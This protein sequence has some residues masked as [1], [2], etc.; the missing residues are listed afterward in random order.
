M[1]TMNAQV[2][3]MGWRGRA[4]LSALVMS[5]A[6]RPFAIDQMRRRLDLD[7]IGAPIAELAHAHGL[8]VHMDGARLWN[9]CIATGTQPADCSTRRT[10][11]C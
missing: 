11:L 5:R 10:P 4:G 2:L 3:H 9:A 6:A 8:A 1:L 7:D